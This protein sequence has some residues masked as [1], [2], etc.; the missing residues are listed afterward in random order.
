MTVSR[1]WWLCREDLGGQTTEGFGGP[2]R[3]SQA[4]LVCGRLSGSRTTKASPSFYFIGIL[5]V[6]LLPSDLLG[7]YFTNLG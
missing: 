6:S 3:G 2:V 4:T 5:V 7:G 1:P